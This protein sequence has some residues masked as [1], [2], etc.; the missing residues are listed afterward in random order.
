MTIALT[1]D[2]KIQISE[3]AERRIPHELIAR[4]MGVSRSTLERRFRDEL[5]LGKANGEI[6]YRK[7]LH[8]MAMAGDFKA[9]LLC[10]KW[11]CGYREPSREVHT[12]IDPAQLLADI[13]AADAATI[14]DPPE[15]EE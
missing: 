7:K 2:Q 9:L 15:G 10:L 6:G 1:E 5:D 3:L 13:K 4:V 11:Y 14:I 12:T 8:E